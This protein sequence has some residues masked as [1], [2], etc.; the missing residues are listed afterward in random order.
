MSNK[1]LSAQ[2]ETKFILNVYED[3]VD[4]ERI[5]YRMP[6][7]AEIFNKLNV[8][9]KRRS[10][11]LVEAS[12][13]ADT[14]GTNPS[15]HFQVTEHYLPLGFS[16]TIVRV[17]FVQWDRGD[18]ATR[19]Y[20]VP[21][22]AVVPPLTN[23]DKKKTFL[24][25]R[26]NITKQFNIDDAVIKSI[27]DKTPFSNED[28]IPESLKITPTVVAKP[29]EKK[30]AT[31]TPTPTKKPAANEN[32][33]KQSTLVKKKDGK[34]EDQ[35]QTEQMR[36]LEKQ[37]QVLKEKITGL[38]QIGEQLKTLADDR[39]NEIKML[40]TEVEQLTEDIVET[41]QENTLAIALANARFGVAN[42]FVTTLEKTQGGASRYKEALKKAED[43]VTQK[44]STKQLSSGL[45]AIA[46]PVSIDGFTES[47]IY[48]KRIKS[49]AKKG[50]YKIHL[51]TYDA[52]TGRIL[53]DMTM[54]Y[55]HKIA[56]LGPTSKTMYGVLFNNETRREHRQTLGRQ[57]KDLL[58]S[59]GSLTIRVT[60]RDDR[61]LKSRTIPYVVEAIAD[62][63]LYALESGSVHLS[64]SVDEDSLF[65]P[66]MLLVEV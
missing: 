45:V 13:I 46:K 61:L 5:L 12:N 58:A 56:A 36:A 59:A 48:T 20:Y 53:L 3:I 10:W 42:T 38:E 30:Q 50:A 21:K 41:V 11:K 14:F 24:L 65:K 19:I 63:Y 25:P 60:D 51:T 17:S 64:M 40:T 16:S 66:K 32:D 22:D 15:G 31:P 47:E 62:N 6:F 52:D 18:Q 43:A 4:D 44:Y 39:E 2:H 29:T 55:V 35:Q 37:M 23:L 49:N 8:N 1:K 27:R 9:R 28:E 33:T 26:E 57:N 7:F 54:P 34:S